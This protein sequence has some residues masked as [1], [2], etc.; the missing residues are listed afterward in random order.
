MCDQGRGAKR[1][2][3]QYSMCFLMATDGEAISRA[4]LPLLTKAERWFCRKQR[5]K[6]QVG[7]VITGT[8]VDSGGPR[9]HFK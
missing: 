6:L 3:G 4:N 7:H 8:S 1:W 2:Q 5:H 9:P